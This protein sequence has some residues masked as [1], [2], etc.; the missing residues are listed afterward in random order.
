M[1]TFLRSSQSDRPPSYSPYRNN[2]IK[3][4]SRWNSIE[5]TE[6]VEIVEDNLIIFLF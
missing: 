4:F 2:A 6:S 1:S 5:S 3:F